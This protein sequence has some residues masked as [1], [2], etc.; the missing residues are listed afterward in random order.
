MLRIDLAKKKIVRGPIPEDLRLSLI[1]GR[2]IAK[3]LLD[4]TRPLVD[5]Y[6]PRNL[7]IFGTGARFSSKTSVVHSICG[8]CVRNL[9][10]MGFDRLISRVCVNHVNLLVKKENGDARAAP[11]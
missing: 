8:L 4:G 3:I 11:S 10:K 7:L 6:S 5:A 9:R 1:G 2:G